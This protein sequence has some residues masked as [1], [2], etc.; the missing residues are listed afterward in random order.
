ME[1][2]LESKV[3][4]FHPVIKDD[5]SSDDVHVLDLSYTNNELEDFNFE[6]NIDLNLLTTAE[7]VELMKLLARYPEEIR[8]SAVNKQPHNM[9]S[10]A[11]DLA[12][13]FHVFYNKCR[14]ITGDD[15]LTSAR[16]Y[17]VKATQQVLQNV[18]SLLGLNAPEQM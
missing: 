5:F 7:E 10:F 3:D 6:D 15:K 8:I 2:I 17:L 16:V 1:K 4:L 13:A 18:L 12:N 9:A 11:Y 14:V